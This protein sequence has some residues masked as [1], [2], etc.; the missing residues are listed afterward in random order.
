MSGIIPIDIEDELKTSYMTYAMSVIVSRALPDVRDGLKP[1]HR[2]ILHSMNEMGLQATKPYKKCGR[3]VGD[4]LGKFHPHGDI[5]IY[6]TLAR[7]AQTFS[8]R[9]ISVDGQGNFG[10]VDGDPPAAMRY[11]EARLSKISELMLKD[12]NKETVNFGPNYDDSMQEPLVLPAAIP[13]LLINGA[14][15]IAVGMAT[16]IPP[17]NIGEVVNAIVAQIEN[18]EITIDEL[19]KFITGPD[20]PTGG[21]IFGRQGIKNAFRTGRGH[22]TIRA[23]VA[24]EETTSG[25]EVIIVNELPYQVNKANLII[26][27]AD[28][29]KEDKISGISDIRD[30]SDRDGMRVVIELKKNV[31]PKVVLNQLFNHTDLQVNFGIINLA[32]DNGLPKVLTLKETIKAYIDFRKEVIFRRTKFELRKAEERAHI[33]EGLV[34]ALDNIDEVIRIIRS[35]KDTEAAKTGLMEKF[36]LSELQA[37]AIVE[38][39]LRQLTSL[40]S[41]KLKEEF[42]EL[43]KTIAKLKEILASDSKVLMVVKNEL[44]EDTKPFIDKRKTEIVDLEVENFEIEDLIQNENMVVTITHRGFIKRLNLSEFKSQGKGGVGVSASS[45][46]DDD[47]LEHLFVAGT[48]DFVLIFSNKG[49]VYQL[50]VHEIPQLSKH[51][52]GDT[53][54]TL[55]GISPN[56]E[57]S[58]VLI[59]KNFDNENQSVF[60]ATCKGIVKRVQLKEF[61]NVKQT[62]KKAIVLDENDSVIDVKITDGIPNK[63][64][65]PKAIEANKYTNDFLLQIE[66][67]DDRK[68]VESFYVLKED[69]I[70]YVFNVD[71]LTEENEKRFIDILQSCKFGKDVL[72]TTKRGKALRFNEEKVR[73]MGRASHG[74]MGIRLE[75]G[76]EVCG[77]CVLIE[78]ALMLLITD[79]G[80]GKRIDPDLFTPHGRGTGGQ[81]CYKIGEEKG[82]IVGVKQVSGEDDV[83]AITSKGHII[84]IPTDQISK[85]GRNA[86]GIRLVK[87]T[88]P[89]FVIAIARSP[90]QEETETS[91]QTQEEASSSKEE[92]ATSPEE[93]MNSNLSEEEDLDDIAIEKDSD[94]D[95][96]DE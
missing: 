34:I 46:R 12:I 29:V 69:G 93:E 36:S 1:V 27:M 10:S 55:I 96:T 11:T 30:E 20:F 94:D 17:H 14:S 43:Q 31:I 53:I 16:N 61:Q 74:V 64:S 48:H 92:T 90:K 41:Y 2:R 22:I 86:G 23:K 37:S 82:E 6:E 33:L 66:N 63:L 57:V 7:M 3:I 67:E 42:E 15:G 58:A 38:M 8:L 5:A 68:F 26:R 95:L 13:Y 87:V 59:V 70:K 21:V 77:L 49:L 9:Y 84:K 78:D 85:Q 75:D 18:P 4:V 83:I 19:M 51:A 62:G 71:I 79:N 60:F 73:V 28:L 56:E 89:D 32:L 25:R 45:L 54:K 88:T 50:K 44:I 81:R 65:I 72:L 24:I 80:F 52:R 39:R 91:S 40:E 47:F 35:A 76:D